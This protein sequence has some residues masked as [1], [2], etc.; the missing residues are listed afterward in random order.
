MKSS[1]GLS[2]VKKETI[3]NMNT[4]ETMVKEAIPKKEKPP[5]PTPAPA[6]SVPKDQSVPSSF[7]KSGFKKKQEPA[8]KPAKEEEKYQKYG[9]GFKM[10][11]MMGFTADQHK[12][13]VHVVKRED[14]QGLGVKKERHM[15]FEG[16]NKR[17]DRENREDI[18]EE[19]RIEV[20]RQE[21]QRKKPTDSDF[22]QFLMKTSKETKE[23]KRKKNVEDVS[24]DKEIINRKS[25]KIIDETGGAGREMY[26]RNQEFME[27]DYGKLNLRIFDERDI[28]DRRELINWCIANSMADM[29]KGFLQ[30]DFRYFNLSSIIN[31]L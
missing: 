17:E 5:T 15:Y 4:S 9:K 10:L 30:S 8:A 3:V 12:E 25:M 27:D 6:S 31:F 24:I 11:K 14:G 16:K 2:F 18:E 19:Q 13:I 22:L 26:L 29:K 1:G 23:V 28:S 7:G 21:I 20:E